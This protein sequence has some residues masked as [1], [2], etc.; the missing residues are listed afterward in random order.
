VVG[1]EVV[2]VEEVAV[3]FWEGMMIIE[4]EGKEFVAVTEL[5]VKLEG[6]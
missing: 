4:V 1:V 5:G 3:H 2:G 6:K